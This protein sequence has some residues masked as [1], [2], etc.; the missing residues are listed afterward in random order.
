MTGK[1][2]MDQCRMVN[3]ICIAAPDGGSHYRGKL[4][5]RCCDK[6]QDMRVRPVLQ[7]LSALEND[8]AVPGTRYCSFTMV[9]V[10]A[11]F[12]VSTWIT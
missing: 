6:L 9:L 5:L 10:K 12:S 4:I 1:H 3:A 8:N 7:Q 2:R 11:P